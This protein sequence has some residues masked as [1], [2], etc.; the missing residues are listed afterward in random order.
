MSAVAI[1]VVAEERAPCNRPVDNCAQNRWLMFLDPQLEQAFRADVLEDMQGSVTGVAIK[2]LL[3]Y[4]LLCSSFL[5]A[6]V[7][8]RGI[9]QGKLTPATNLFVTCSA[10]GLVMFV[11]VGI[12]LWARL[13]LHYDDTKSKESK[14][15]A[16]RTAQLAILPLYAV[17][18]S[19]YS[20]DNYNRIVDHYPELNR[21]VF[22]GNFIM[23]NSIP[24]ELFSSVYV[25]MMVAGTLFNNE[26]FRP[27]FKSCFNN[28]CWNAVV[29]FIHL[30]VLTDGW[31]HSVYATAAVYLLGVSSEAC[32]LHSVLTLESARRRTFLD[33]RSLARALAE[34]KR[35]QGLRTAIAHERGRAQAERT[36]V[37]YLC[38]EVK[39][40]VLSCKCLP[41]LLFCT[42]HH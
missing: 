42:A 36:I 8:E 7:A 13:R 28:F 27:F 30:W 15:E 1:P 26:T 41:T 9:F 34:E 14:V 23:N 3:F 19:L 10:L 25:L 20:L 2:P 12:M 21:P 37:A 31:T 16:S 39:R 18:C 6:F 5:T 33:R 24:A 35:S 22:E 40:W 11:C 17:C 32:I 38:H 4:M 29:L